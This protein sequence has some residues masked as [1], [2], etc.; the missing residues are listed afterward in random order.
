MLL[1]CGV[2]TYVYVPLRS[3]TVNDFLTLKFNPVI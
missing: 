1:T 2:Q 3:F